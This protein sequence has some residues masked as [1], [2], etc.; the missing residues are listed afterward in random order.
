MLNWVLFCNTVRFRVKRKKNE[1]VLFAAW[2]CSHSVTVGERDIFICFT[3]Y[4]SKYAYLVIITIVSACKLQI[5]H[6]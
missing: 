2:G 5:L 1:V 3:Q 4:K 6:L